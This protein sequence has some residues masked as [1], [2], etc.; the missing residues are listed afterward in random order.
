VKTNRGAFAASPQQR[1]SA[2]II[3]YY[4]TVVANV[5]QQFRHQNVHPTAA[6]A[7]FSQGRKHK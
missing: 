2:L 3:E 4:K 5:D 1:L 7:A 6:G